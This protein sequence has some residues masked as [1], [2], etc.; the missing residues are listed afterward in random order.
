MGV[1]T[2]PVPFQI[3]VIHKRKRSRVKA[4]P[5]HSERSEECTTSNLLA[6]LKGLLN[7][8]LKLTDNYI[9]TTLVK[10]ATVVGSL[11]TTKETV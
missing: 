3:P 8:R 11:I 6:I 4:S 10:L 2:P 7:P 9:I 5:K 1:P